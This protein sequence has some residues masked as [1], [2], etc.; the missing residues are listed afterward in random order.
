MQRCPSS[1]VMTGARVRS[2]V[3]E[4]EG[5]SAGRAASAG[6][7][8]SARGVASAGG[9]ASVWVAAPV[10][11]PEPAADAMYQPILLRVCTRSVPPLSPDEILGLTLGPKGH[12]IFIGM[13]V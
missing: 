9:A 7:E 3:S 4:E 10:E 6:G 1:R 13:Y 12:C 2:D 8:A 11:M 5:T